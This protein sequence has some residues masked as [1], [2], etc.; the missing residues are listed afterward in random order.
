MRRHRGVDA[1]DGSPPGSAAEAVEAAFLKD[2]GITPA[3][4]AA[5]LAAF[6]A[7][8]EAAGLLPAYTD[9]YTLRR[10]LRARGHDL[11]RARSMWEG[12]LAWRAAFGVDSLIQDFHFYER[13]AF[14]ALYP[15]GYHGV[16][17]LG[18]PVFIQ[19]LGRIDMKQLAA[20]TTQDRMLKFH[21]QEYE[22]CLRYI[23]PACSRAAGRHVDQT[24][25]ILDVG[26]VGL[27]HMTGEV[28]G[29]LAAITGIDQDNYPETLGKTVIINAPA[30]FK[31]IWAV[32][33]PMLDV[34]TAAKI[35]VCSSKYLPTLLK[36]VSPDQL[37]EYMGGTSRATLL[38]DV[39][40]WNDPGT[41]AAIDAEIA[42][43]RGW[44]VGGGR[45]G[46]DGGRGEGERGRRA[47][48]PG[49]GGIQEEE[50]GPPPPP[51]PPPPAAPPGPPP[52]ALSSPPLIPLAALRA[53][54]PSASGGPGG[55]EGEEEDGWATPRSA[56][57]SLSAAPGASPAPEEAATPAS[58]APPSAAALLDRVRALEAALGSKAPA[59]AAAAAAA[60]AGGGGGGGGARTLAA[61]VEALEVA[62]G[63]LLAREESAVAAERA[64]RQ[65]RQPQPGCACAVM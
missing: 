6:R 40:P 30:A 13:D 18:R 37:P 23:F 64:E 36:Y 24:F 10:F 50:G 19:H 11:G 1:A 54:T 21:V 38:D 22:R 25:A 33:R 56:A 12:H 44:G 49:R 61:R 46:G 27:R 43:G 4:E 34:R 51:P 5:R 45:V 55:E 65:Q 60:A 42:A 3:T 17:R 16:D 15:Q 39:G 62:A 53:A 14:L 29:M 48:V 20:T 28:K 9:D 57:S 31:M 47:P 59:A 8:L 52:P 26:G 2:W 58:A 63:V 32:V 35:E 41:I 7:G